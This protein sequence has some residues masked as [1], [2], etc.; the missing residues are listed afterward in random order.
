MAHFPRYNGPSLM[1]RICSVENLTLAWRRVRQNIE[2]ARRHRSAGVDAVTLRDFEA[3]WVRQM[4]ELAGQLQD[5]SYRPLPPRHVAIPKRSGGERALAILAVRDRIAQ[6]AV[7]QVLEPLFDPYFL[8]CSFGCRPGIG[9]PEA[10]ARVSRYAEQNLPWV[11]DADIAE[12]FDTIDHRHLMALLRQRITEQPVLQLIARW[13]Q[14]GALSRAADPIGGRGDPPDSPIGRGR[15]V[16]RQAL[17]WLADRREPLEE[18]PTIA[19]GAELVDWEDMQRDAS[20]FPQF[21]PAMLWEAATLARPWLRGAQSLLPRL[22]R[23]G[24]HRLLLAG[25]VA[26]SALLAT[27]VIARRRS[28]SDRRGTA[29]GGPLS[30]LLA[31]IYLHPFDVA[32][33]TEGWRLVRYVDDFVI[34]CADENEAGR[35]LDAA[36]CHLSGLRLALSPPKTQV[37]RYAD[38]LAFLGQ[39][40]A[41]RQRGPLLEDGLT[42]FAEA[43]RALRAAA[44]Q[45]RQRV[46]V[47][48]HAPVSASPPLLRDYGRRVLSRGPR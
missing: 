16:A 11:V 30:P 32:M 6:R 38:G 28:V 35:A 9:V 36:R 20:T 2:L 33:T 44:Q 5:G 14:A 39:D 15:Q 43:E 10:V 17:D 7:F 48:R 4:S 13:L 29:Q 12:Y 45:A 25:A 1:D 18:L 19:R 41:P 23:I 21:N 8:D 47:R 46:A 27:E 22:Q 24:T 31:N 42:T 3:D 37:V 40:L 26:T 34:M